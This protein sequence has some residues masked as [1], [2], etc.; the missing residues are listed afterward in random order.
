MGDPG[1]LWQPHKAMR[2]S[3][4]FVFLLY[5]PWFLAFIPSR[6]KYGFSSSSYG[7]DI[8]DRE[9]ETNISYIFLS[10]FQMLF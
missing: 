1:L 9:T 7:F 6:S 5:Y 4:T 3:E 2:K 8:S 10:P